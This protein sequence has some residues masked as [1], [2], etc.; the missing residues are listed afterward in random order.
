[1]NDD[2][3]PGYDDETQLPLQ[4]EPAD[5]G[6]SLMESEA[7][8][9]GALS[10]VPDALRPALERRGFAELTAV[11]VAVL[12]AGDT[13][14]DLQISSQ[15]GSG[16]TIALGLV[17]APSLL[18]SGAAQGEPARGPV[19]LVIVPT[20]ELAAQVCGEL[21]WL[22]ADVSAVTLDCVTG[23]TNPGHERGRLQKKPRVLVGTPGRLLD[24]LTCGALKLESVQHLVL[25][26]A[27]QMLDM[28]FREDL[29][30]ILERTPAERRTH[31]VSATF[32]EG[33][34]RLAARYQ[35]NPLHI[36]GTRLGV[37]NADI[38][39]LAY[40][41]RD[42]DRYAALVNLLLIGGNE[43]TLVFV[44]RRTETAELADKLTRDGFSAL[45]LS[46]ELVQAQR[47][48]TLAA[49]KQGSASILVATDVASR[50]LDVP[51]VATVVHTTP[52]FDAEV[53]THRSGRTGRAG[54]KG[55]SILLVPINKERKVRRLL[56]GANVNVQWPDLPDAASVQRIL[57]KRER[58]ATWEALANAPD[59][60]E[61]RIEQARA[62]LDGRDAEH[63][64]ATVLE[65]HK[66]ES[67]P[68]PFE[69][70]V[71]TAR[72]RPD[73]VRNERGYRTMSGADRRPARSSSHSNEF[74]DSR[75]DGDS[76]RFTIN[77]GFTAGANPKRL[78]AHICRRGGI[79]GRDVGAIRL[80]GRFSTFE[81]QSAVVRDFESRVR[82]RDRRDPHLRI[83][84]DGERFRPNRRAFAR[85]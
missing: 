5:A 24:H 51:D 25:D 28:G 32:P 77:W 1:M 15:T 54:N 31:L 12:D 53:Y 85:S 20:R 67:G 76:V 16:K 83:Q 18:P 2:L 39:H 4:A 3:N 65:M 49:F 44:N 71:P 84:R 17:T 70:E 60:S 58:R 11:Q 73:S 48:R 42:P 23:G 80:Q 22:Y 79:Q 61:E 10:R 78:L 59:P 47:T 13:A 81:V 14:R 64:L 69:I 74:Q 72:Q 62:L 19:V 40:R 43:R 34:L 35:T 26:E 41:V 29:E 63:V 30:A 66:S 57:K 75:D 9:A 21:A 55:K 52:G 36:E 46:G 45:P 50:G 82:A 7:D 8:A 33:I 6:S 56:S 37:A 27:D 68:A 38:E